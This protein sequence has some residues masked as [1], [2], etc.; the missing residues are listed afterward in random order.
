MTFKVFTD[1]GS[2]GNPGPAACAFVIYSD[3]G[4][5]QD[6]RGKPLDF[7]Q[8]KYLGV[9]TNNEAEYY[10]VIEALCHPELARP[11]RDRRVSGSKINFYLDSLLVVNQLNGLWKI[12]EP[13]LRELLMKVKQLENNRQITYTHVPREQNAEADLLVNE[14]LDNQKI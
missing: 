4:V 9:A 14:T 2:R 12:K 6:K 10:G 5:L 8:G 7:A 11:E 13:R 1:G 3:A